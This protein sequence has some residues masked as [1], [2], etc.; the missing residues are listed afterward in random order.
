ME[1]DEEI[2]IDNIPVR[3]Y[4]EKVLCGGMRYYVEKD[5]Q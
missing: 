5:M 2:V 4:V 1:Q 3:Y